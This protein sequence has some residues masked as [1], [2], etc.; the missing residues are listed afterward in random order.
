MGGVKITNIANPESNQDA[1]TMLYAMDNF[2]FKYTATATTTNA[3]PATIATI[4]LDAS[5]TTLVTAFV[6][7]RR[8]GGSAGTA[9][10][11]LAFV[12][13]GAFKMISGVATQIGLSL[14][15]IVQDKF[16]W[17]A[18]LIVSSGNVLVQGT[19]AINTNINW[20]VVYQIIKV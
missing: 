13:N 4:P 11:G 10:D 5:T 9:E 12:I 1:M 6:V 8:T 14:P 20:K 18:N 7:A 3:T 19:G 2:P 16:I 17:N 15:T